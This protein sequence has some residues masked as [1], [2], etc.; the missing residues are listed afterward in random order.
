VTGGQPAQR[1]TPLVYANDW[2]YSMP[3][4]DLAC[5]VALWSGAE[6]MAVPI[7]Q[8]SGPKP[9]AASAL[10]D[11]AVRGDHRVVTGLS[12][13]LTGPLRM[14]VGVPLPPARL[15]LFGKIAFLFL[16]YQILRL[17]TNLHWRLARAPLRLRTHPLGPALAAAAS[18]RW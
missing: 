1:S 6:A 12:R 15:L 2:R 3:P 16:F 7:F 5:H 8:A 4:A 9:F 10:R 13:S 14:L 11:R 18:W 17:V